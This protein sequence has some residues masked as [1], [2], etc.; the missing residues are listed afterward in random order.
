VSLE[1]RSLR[2][3]L[4]GPF[5]FEVPAGQCLAISGPS[6]SGKSLLMRM[7]A[8]LDPSEGRVL[9]DGDDRTAMPVTTWRQR[10]SLVPAR[11]GWWSDRVED[12]FDPA[13]ADE[14]RE[15]STELY[16]PENLFGRSIDEASTG[17]RQRLAIVR[18]LLTRP[19]VL[20]LDEPTASLDPTTTLAVEALVA[21][22]LHDGMTL[23]LVTHDAAQAGRMANVRLHMQDHRLVPA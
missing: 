14:R 9:L 4:A 20:L 16:L 19:R 15:L 2:S 12:H 6:G 5:S 17:E 13:Q 10:V 21:R 1:V 18:A 7:L 11:S 23:V 3:P 22:R 8:D